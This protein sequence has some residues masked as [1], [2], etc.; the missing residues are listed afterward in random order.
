MEKKI[1]DLSLHGIVRK[2]AKIVDLTSG[3][4]LDFSYDSAM[5]NIQIENLNVPLD[6]TTISSKDTVEIIKIIY[7]DTDT[8]AEYGGKFITQWNLWNDKID[9]ISKQFS[10]KGIS[11]LRKSL[12]TKLSLLSTWP[13]TLISYVQIKL[14]KLKHNVTYLLLSYVLHVYKPIKKRI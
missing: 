11:K 2:P 4:S 9:Q 8:F 6:F 3:E 12:T 5:Q 13:N 10:Q 7:K 1:I 14:Q